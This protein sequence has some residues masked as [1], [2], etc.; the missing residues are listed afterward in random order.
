[1][2]DKRG[3]EWYKPWVVRPDLLRSQQPRVSQPPRAAVSR[4]NKLLKGRSSSSTRLND[5]A[6]KLEIPETASTPPLNRMTAG[7]SLANLS[8]LGDADAD[9]INNR[10]HSLCFDP[11]SSV[12]LSLDETTDSN[13]NDDEP[14]LYSLPLSNNGDLSSVNSFCL[15]KQRLVA[16]KTLS[17]PFKYFDS[18]GERYLVSPSLKEYPN[19]ILT[20]KTPN[21]YTTA[22]RCPSP[23]SKVANGVFLSQDFKENAGD[24][25]ITAKNLHHKRRTMK[26]KYI[27]NR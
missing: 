23:H 22:R 25:S 14:S 2:K 27:Q 12:N 20:N 15:E 6:T 5:I 9:A 3:D 21:K 24:T 4:N 10:Y 13:N 16:Q 11:G 19:S 18:D 17:L 1:M 8:Q 26:C 7:Y